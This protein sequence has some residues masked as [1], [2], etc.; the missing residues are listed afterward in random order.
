VTSTSEAHAPARMQAADGRADEMQMSPCCIIFVVP[1][2]AG[3]WGAVARD[4]RL[5]VCCYTDVGSERWNFG[6]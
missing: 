2:D 4:G 3:C 5:Q 1:T 6:H